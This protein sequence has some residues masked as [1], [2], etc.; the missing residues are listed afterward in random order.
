MKIAQVSAVDF[1]FWHF[2]L[3]LALAERQ[4]GH[5]V[6]AVCSPGPYL[7]RI[8]RAGVR[9][10]PIGIPRGLAPGRLIAT[11]RALVRLF[12]AERFDMVHVHTPVAAAL[13]RLAAWRAGVPHVVYTA[14]GFYF[15]E[16]MAWWRRAVF[17]AAEWL[18]GRVT[19]VLLTQAEE[20]AAFARRARL[21]P[22]PRPIVAIGNGVDPRAFGP[23][24]AAA[25]ARLRRDLATP[26]DA[27]VVVQ[28][29]RLVAEKGWAELIAAMREVPAHLWIVGARL[30]SDPDDGIE[31]VLAAA[32]PDLAPRLRVLGARDD[33][34]ALLGAADVFVLASHREGMPRS[35]IEAMMTG[36]PVVA[37]AVRGSREL[38][39]PDETGLLVP[40]GDAAALGAALARLVVDRALRARLGQAGRARAL[41]LY[42]ERDVI[43]RQLALLGLAP[44]A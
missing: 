22:E 7:A 42:D 33:V 26:E 21:L 12:V 24:D 3:P 30:P 34:A 4:A 1:T 44:R 38:V 18:L 5:E 25:R 6:V 31:D 35:V 37:T 9:V 11:Y 16:R 13:A 36:L 32:D 27:V 14:H 19:D 39:V 17:V 8:R 15:H 2:L 41:A 20:D 23:G 40:V 43:A 29:G 10:A 28:V